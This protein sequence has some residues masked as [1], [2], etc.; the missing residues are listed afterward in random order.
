MPALAA[1]PAAIQSL[2][3]HRSPIS[4]LVRCEVV[5]LYDGSFLGIVWSFIKPVLMLTVYAFVF[6]VVFKS[7]RRAAFSGPLE[8]PVVMFG[9]TIIHAM[10]ADFLMRAGVDRRECQPRQG[11]RISASNAGF[12]FGGYGCVPFHN[13]ATDPRRC[14]AG[15]ARHDP[16]GSSFRCWWRR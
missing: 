6:G 4:Q 7:R 8:S 10:M 5:G 9:G 3:V 15:L 12:G 16:P 13:R 11:D 1:P 14:S 2:W